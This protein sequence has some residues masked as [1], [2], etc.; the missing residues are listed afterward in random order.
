MQKLVKGGNYTRKYGVYKSWIKR[1]LYLARIILSNGDVTFPYN[2]RQVSGEHEIKGKV[3]ISLHSFDPGIKEC[4]V[5][6]T[7]LCITRPFPEFFKLDM[8]TIC[9]N[10]MD[11]ILLIQPIGISSSQKPI[12]Q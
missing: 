3:I 6:A 4:Q 12:L 2:A 11:R 5:D 1:L 9:I 7:Y 10:N 8:Q